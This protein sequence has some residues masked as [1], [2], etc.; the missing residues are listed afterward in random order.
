[1]NCVFWVL[2]PTSLGPSKRSPLS[3]DEAQSAH[4]QFHT[5]AAQKDYLQSSSSKCTEHKQQQK[6]WI[7]VICSKNVIV[8]S[9]R[10][11]TQELIHRVHLF[12][13]LGFLF[14]LFYVV[15]LNHSDDSYQWPLVMNTRV[16]QKKSN[17][18]NL[19]QP[20]LQRACISAWDNFIAPECWR[21]GKGRRI[22]IWLIYTQQRQPVILGP[23]LLAGQVMR[24]HTRRT[25]WERHPC[26][27]SSSAAGLP[28]ALFI[29][30]REYSLY[31]A[32]SFRRVPSCWLL[33]NPSLSW[34][35]QQRIQNNTRR[36]R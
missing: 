18:Y 5:A 4:F 16:Q 26:L 33:Y 9:T 1:M 12:S 21:H 2:T 35:D 7:T 34:T 27:F 17:Q 15:F 31:P 19:H 32:R 22:K 29:N 24:L 14:I 3:G 6:F 13:V 36:S 23:R 25:V 20:R 10:S 11:M 30:V 28:V 8:T